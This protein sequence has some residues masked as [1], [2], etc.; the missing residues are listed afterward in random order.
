MSP[1]DPAAV[2]RPRPHAARRRD[3]P[4]TLA[5]PQLV[6]PLL[7]AFLVACGDASSND[8]DTGGGPPPTEDALPSADAYDTAADVPTPEDAG[9]NDAAPDDPRDD[10]APGD[11][12]EDGD[13]N[14]DDAP[15]GGGTEPTDVADDANADDVDAPDLTPWRSEL[16]PDDWTPPGPDDDEAALEDYSW[17]GYAAGLRDEGPPEGVALW[18]V[19]DHGLPVDDAG[20]P[21]PEVDAGPAIQAALDAAR[22]A[23][24]GVVLLPPGTMR[25]DGRLRITGEG[26]VLRGA[27]VDRT[28]LAFTRTEGM[29]FAAHLLVGGPPRLGAHVP[30]VADAASRGHALPLAPDAACEPGQEIVLGHVITP[31]FIEDHRMTGTWRAF[32]DRWVPFAWRTIVACD[33]VDAAGNVVDDLDQAVALHARVDVPLREAHRVRDDASVRSVT[34]SARECGIEDLALSN[35]VAWEDAWARTQVHIVALEGVRDG[36]V[37]RVRSFPSPWA[38]TPEGIE[39]SEVLSS[40]VLVLQSRFVTIRD[41]HMANAQHRGTGGN[42]YLFELRQ[43]NEVLTVDAS[44]RNG[45][46]NFIQNWGFGASGNVWL[47]IHSEG[48]AQMLSAAWRIPVPAASEFHHSLATSNLIDQSRIVDRW[49]AR[50]RGDYSTGAGQTAWKNVFWNTSGGGTLQ[51]LQHG[52][53]FVIGTSPDIRV[54][55]DPDGIVR[56]PLSAPEDWREGEGRGASLEPPSLY[57][58]Q[59]AMRRARMGV[60]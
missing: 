30:L 50:D 52:L 48:S 49:E 20:A 11:I 54:L 3:A 39:P 58:A 28:R 16:F 41:V 19:L 34:W 45:R 57:E 59:L 4:L 60:E 27:G 42:G 26:V 53:G 25:V 12:T 8:S 9:D 24:G 46:H 6:A 33:W 32:N 22:D 1:R 13:T 7:F 29:D 38:T 10:A 2:L 47:R 56:G 15:D 31:Q 21:D 36:W 44:A 17:A 40:G 18:D 35:A 43:S 51:S 37:R 55:T 5:A 14:D 23:G